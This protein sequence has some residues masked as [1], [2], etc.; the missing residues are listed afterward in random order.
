VAS[1]KLEKITLKEFLSTWKVWAADRKRAATVPHTNA[2]DPIPER[3]PNA[4][5]LR[6]SGTLSAYIIFIKQINLS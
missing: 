1:N 3:T 2:E 6:P 4:L 5:L